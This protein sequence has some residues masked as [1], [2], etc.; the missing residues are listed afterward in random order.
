MSD[1]QKPGEL[2]AAFKSAP[3]DSPSQKPTLYHDSATTVPEAGAP[4]RLP[5]RM[6]GY[7]V[8]EELGRGG[9]GVVYRVHDSRL[10]RSLA[11]KVLLEQ[12]RGDAGLRERFLE[13]A[14][15]MG[16]LQH[17]GVA[18]IHELGE[19]PDGRAFF[20]MKQIHGRTLAEILKDGKRDTQAGAV[21]DSPRAA[22]HAPPDLPRL[23]VIFEQVCQT[24]AF[25]HSRGI[26]HRDLKPANLMVGAFGEVQVM[27]WG[28]AKRS[29]IANG[30]L[31][32]ETEPATSTDSSLQSSICNLKSSE[33]QAGTVLGTAAYMAPEQAR[34]E[35]ELL[36][37]RADVFGLGG[38][39]C[40]ILT[41]QPPFTG[42][43]RLD[44]QRKAMK[45]DLAETLARLDGCGAD[46]ELLA[47]ARHCLAPER[48][49]RPRDA[50]AVAE[51]V[52]AY[53]AGVQ[54]RLRQAE[55]ERAQAQV[56]A[57]EEHKRV[58]VERQK[59]RV[60]ATLALV[61]VALVLTV[62]GVAFWLVRD[63]EVRDQRRQQLERDLETQ[64]TGLQQPRKQLH[65]RLN[66]PQEAAQLL[67]DIGGWKTQVERLRETWQRTD[68]VRKA[69]EGLLDESWDARLAEEDQ[70]IKDDENDWAF[71]KRLDDIRLEAGTLIEGK[72]NPPLAARKYPQAFAGLGLSLEQGEPAALAARIGQS[73]IRPALVAALDFWAT[74]LKTGDP[75][76]P[77]LLEIARRADPDPYGDQVRDVTNHDK[78]LALSR[79]SP[80]AG[81]SPQLILLLAWR[82]RS[83][84]SKAA[85]VLVR[86]AVLTQPR[87]FWLHFDLGNLARDPAERAGCFQAALALRPEDLMTRNNLAS[88]LHA[89]K[90]LDGA[91]Q[92]Y[93][94][95]LSLD[96][97]FVYA[98]TGFGVVLKARGDLKGAIEHYQKALAIDP[99][100]APAHNNLGRALYEKRDLHGAIRCYHKALGLDPDSAMTHNNLGIALMYG[101]KDLYGAMSSFHKALALDADYAPAHFNL[102]NALKAQ[103]DLKGAIRSFRKALDLNLNLPLCH[104][105]LANALKDTGDLGGAIQHYQKALDLDPR[106]ALAHI[107]LGLAL[108]AQGKLSAALAALRTGHALGSAQPG[109][110][111]PSAD[112][113][114]ECERLLAIEQK[115]SGGK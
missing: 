36:D 102:G 43:G 49:G 33:T 97:K 19:L 22:Q 86:Q 79:Q 39:L 72:W 77:R 44:C 107:N 114:K 3:E 61:G 21:H 59:R 32:I 80:P 41:G 95:A 64:L 18:P 115:R 104:N 93:Q 78:L 35:V 25:A 89:R 81:A 91:M 5:E 65:A 92:C 16:Q 7:E 63:R 34:G 70:Y 27:D 45:G 9:M 1:A 105:N 103:G 29:Q 13:E 55:I 60:T 75:L 58:L 47:L 28:L 37:A 2:T 110:R 82:V 94:K 67:S 51:A 85:A 108:Q 24:L 68:A 54:D 88:A 15:I 87:D 83:Q 84:D 73:K 113:L 66:N 52:A 12:H 109:W 14:Q 62:A 50:A 98:H 56:K 112:L 76:L 30:R 4:S 96:P 106:Y 6:G 48:E 38:I 53:Q 74:V 101:K 8:K 26:I 10:N 31:Q 11:V 23:L 71:A 69:G 100:F 40:T 57:V 46:A 17:P 111:V 20:A 42:A 90:D 99:N